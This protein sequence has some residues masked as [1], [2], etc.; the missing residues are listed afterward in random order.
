LPAA[1]VSSPCQQPL[2][3]ALAS[4]PCQ[5]PLPAALASS[6]CQQPLP[7]ALVSSPCQQIC[8]PAHIKNTQN[9]FKKENAGKHTKQLKTIRHSHVCFW[10]LPL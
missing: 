3:A 2:P 5:Q 8:S 6:P 7:A 9:I 10:K 1:L 4:S